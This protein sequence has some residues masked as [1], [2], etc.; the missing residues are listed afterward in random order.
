MAL[1]ADALATYL[2]GA[3]LAGGI[4][5]DTDQLT[6]VCRA[7]S[8]IADYLNANTPNGEIHITLVALANPQSI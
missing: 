2:K 3:Y 1:D 7:I 4:A 8:K 6:D 5:V